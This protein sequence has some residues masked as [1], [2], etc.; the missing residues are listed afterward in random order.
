MELSYS[1][2]YGN[3]PAVKREGIVELEA[4]LRAM[5][6]SMNEDEA[7]RAFNTHYFAPGVYGRKMTVPAGMCIVGKI[8]KYD[9]MIVILSGVVKVV[10]EHQSETLVGPHIFI[11]KAGSKRAI[12]TIE[13]TVWLNVHSNPG[14]SEDI[15]QL[16]SDIIAETYEEFDQLNL[17]REV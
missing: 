2:E 7:E 9:H 4:A 11:A 16:E 15:K 12:Y 1:Y 5:P 17:E 13:D 3:L 8:H 10:S 14:D 6:G